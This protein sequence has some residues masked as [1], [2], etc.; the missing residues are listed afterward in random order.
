MEQARQASLQTWAQAQRNALHEATKNTAVNQ[1]PV[2][3]AAAGA[4]GVGGGGGGIGGVIEITW[5]A[6]QYAIGTVEEWNSFFGLGTLHGN[7][8]SPFTD[9]TVQGNK[10]ILSGTQGFIIKENCFS[11]YN[12]LGNQQL[13]EFKD[14]TGCVT[15]VQAK[16]FANCDNLT[17][18]ILPTATEIEF[19]AFSDCSNL[20]TVEIPKATI[21][22]DVA[23]SDC[24]LLE[25]IEIPL[26]EVIGNYVFGNSGIQTITGPRVD[27]LVANALQGAYALTDASFPIATEIGQYAFNNCNS[28][29]TVSAPLAT[30]IGAWCFYN[31]HILESINIP[32]CTNLGGSPLYNGVFDGLYGTFGT[33]GTAGSIDITIDSSRATCGSSGV[34]DTDLITVS[35]QGSNINYV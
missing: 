15:L 27:Y 13:I 32:S 16:A 25:S 9:V 24:P 10:T 26:V 3:A 5:S 1:A 30:S 23:F 22:G 17:T 8:G 12:K 18:A 7:Y 33:S 20:S 6:P 21:L 31:C 29:K 35:G 28:L 2:A 19:C 4:S 11:P 34:P 14:V